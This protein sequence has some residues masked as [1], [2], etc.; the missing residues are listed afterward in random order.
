M[1]VCVVGL[2]GLTVDCVEREVDGGGVGGCVGGQGEEV[3]LMHLSSLVAKGGRC[4]EFV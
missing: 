3:G 4:G 2:K 1:C